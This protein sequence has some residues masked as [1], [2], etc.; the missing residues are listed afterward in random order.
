MAGGFRHPD[1]VVIGG[2]AI[3]L[4]SAWRL[5]QRG[6]AVTV[7]DPAPGSGASTVAAGLLA[8][9]TEARLGEDD[10]LRLNVASWARWPDFAAEVSTAAGV[11]IGYREDGTLLVAL[12]ADDRA[13]LDEGIA[14]QRA[15]GLDVT[16]LRGREV[17][18]A[19]PGL[20]PGV[21]AGAMAAGERRVDT[22]ALVPALHR[23]AAAA[24]VTFVART[25]EQITMSPTGDRVAGVRLG[26]ATL[27][28]S[29]SGRVATAVGADGVTAAARSATSVTASPLAAA[30]G[31]EE[32]VGSSESADS[33]RADRPAADRGQDGVAVPVASV[34][35]DAIEPA[36]E[37]DVIEAGHVVLAAGC[38]SGQVAGVPDEARPPV[39]P[40]RGQ[41]LVL[42][43]P[44]DQPLLGRTVRALV[45]GAHIYLAPRDDGR[46]VVGATVEERGWDTRVTAGGTYELLRDV[47][48]LVPGLD[49]AELVAVEAGLR[50]GSPDDV[51]IIG[52]SAVDGLTV[53][54]GHY[55][56]GI[57]LTPVTADAV[58]AVVTG[59]PPPPEIAAC[60]PQ[61]FAAGR[62]ASV[63]RSAA[64]ASSAPDSP[65]TRAG[66]EVA[67][68]AE[69]ASG[70]VAP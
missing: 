47:V 9:V 60:D 30:G 25:A 12:D 22:K 10:L 24:G 55:R 8:P 45:H 64:V 39:R 21:R 6:L 41:V 23:V 54:T 37:G 5:A 16:P 11:P 13:V 1:V 20:A 17:R 62:S 18:A 68:S 38:W 44:T 35:A 69:V 27:R 28:T 40:V 2:G 50:P 31:T 48:A 49:D 15:L 57:L 14:C 59:D 52:R 42:R 26:A 36:A 63:V 56:N 43:Q 19:E 61:R 32:A 29:P 7:V 51:P 70:E 34:P 46:V 67:P 3:G 65:A 33:A 58:A 53:A 4:A 66:P